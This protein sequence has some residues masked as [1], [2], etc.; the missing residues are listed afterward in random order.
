MSVPV[1]PFLLVDAADTIKRLEAELAAARGE[2]DRARSLDVVDD[3]EG[4]DDLAIVIGQRERWK[5]RARHRGYSAQ[6]LAAERD[7]LRAEAAVLVRDRRVALDRVVSDRAAADRSIAALVDLLWRVHTVLVDFS[8]VAEPPI[9]EE[10]VTALDGYGNGDRHPMTP[11]AERL[12]EAEGRAKFFEAS[13]KS[14]ELELEGVRAAYNKLEDAVGGPEHAAEAVNLDKEL[15][16]KEDTIAEIIERIRRVDE[17]AEAVRKDPENPDLSEQFSAAFAAMRRAAGLEPVPPVPQAAPNALDELEA[18]G[19]PDPC[20]AVLAD[21]TACDGT[22]S[23]H[24]V[25]THCA[26]ERPPIVCTA[27][28]AERCRS[29]LETSTP[30]HGPSEARCTKPIG[31][32]SRCEFW[33]DRVDSL[34]GD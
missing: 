14:R 32:K 2:I 29:V 5:A 11:I 21:G 31:H 25:C 18:A 3:I 13:A 17:C 27:E 19:W 34:G 16:A 7:R 33:P 26:R 10:I 22:F 4:D 28:G 8:T 15:A 6:E 12:A 23:E 20:D 30:E 9:L 24:G 1:D